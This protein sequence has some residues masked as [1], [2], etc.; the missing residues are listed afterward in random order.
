MTS[1]CDVRPR[2]CPSRSEKGDRAFSKKILIF[3]LLK[4]PLSLLRKLQCTALIEK[5]VD[6]V[7]KLKISTPHPSACGCHLLPQEKALN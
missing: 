5:A 3:Y 6:E 4:M 1:Q 2:V 7:L